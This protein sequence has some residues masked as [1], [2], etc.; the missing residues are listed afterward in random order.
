MKHSIR[1][2]V[3]DPVTGL[4]LTKIEAVTG[5]LG[6]GIFDKNGRE[7]FEGDIVTTCYPDEEVVTFADGHFWV[8]DTPIDGYKTFWRD[9]TDTPQDEQFSYDIEVVGHVDD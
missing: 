9:D 1:Q 5:E 2:R 3:L 7:I 4:M 8:G 6:S